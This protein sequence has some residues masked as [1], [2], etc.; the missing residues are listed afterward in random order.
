MRNNLPECLQ[1]FKKL[2]MSLGPHARDIYRLCDGQL[3]FFFVDLRGHVLLD[4]LDIDSRMFSWIE[5]SDMFSS[6][7]VGSI[8][9]ANHEAMNQFLESYSPI[10][11]FLIVIQ[12]ETT[13]SMH[14]VAISNM[15]HDPNDVFCCCKSCVHRRR[16]KRLKLP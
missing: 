8:C 10:V 15:V 9:R 12:T 11:D 14:K 6:D 3:G 5:E 4:G 1:P 2:V 7:L 13:L 16:R